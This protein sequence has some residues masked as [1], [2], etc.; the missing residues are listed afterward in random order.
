MG[1]GGDELLFG[2]ALAWGAGAHVPQPAAHVL[3]ATTRTPAH[4]H[5]GGGRA[6]PRRLLHRQEAAGRRR[7]VRLPGGDQPEQPPG[8]LASETFVSGCSTPPTRSSW[9]TRRTSSSRARR[10]APTWHSTRTS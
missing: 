6:A 5:V 2:L 3:G 10:C 7:A 9:W 4:E 1:N 8:R